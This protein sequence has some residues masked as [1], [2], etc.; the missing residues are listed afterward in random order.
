MGPARMGEALGR[1]RCP[2][3]LEGN[4]QSGE[5]SSE[6]R[7]QNELHTHRGGQRLSLGWGGQYWK[8]VWEEIKK[9]T[10]LAVQWSK[11]LPYNARD[12]GLIPGQETRVP[13]AAEQLSLSAQTTEA[14]VL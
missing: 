4:R 2:T 6:S 10:S 14:H 9:G 7:Q 1:R 3:D 12:S 11:N 5:E 8:E 13:H